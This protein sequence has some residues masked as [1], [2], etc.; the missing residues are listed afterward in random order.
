MNEILLRHLFFYVLLRSSCFSCS[1]WYWFMSIQIG[2]YVKFQNVV[3]VVTKVNPNRTIQI[4]NPQ[5]EGVDSKKSVAERNLEVLPFAPMQ[6]IEHQG[7]YLVSLKGLIISLRTAK[8]MKWDDNNGNRK[9][10][11][12]LAGLAN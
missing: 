5:A 1:F 4:I 8:V 12:G 7:Q 3:Y 9:H 10:I 2:S 11:L 6:I